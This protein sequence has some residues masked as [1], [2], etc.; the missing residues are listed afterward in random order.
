MPQAGIH[1]MVGVAVRR[2]LPKREWLMLGLVVGNLLPDADNLAVAVATVAAPA[3]DDPIRVLHRT[4]THS[5]FF[6]VTLMVVF[7]LVAR[8]RG[9]PRWGN[10]GLGL[11]A[12]VGMHMALD[13]LVW[14]NGVEVLWPIPSWVNLWSGYNPPDWFSKLMYPA[15]FLCFALYFWMLTGVARRRGTD[16]D[17]LRALRVWTWVQAGLFVLFTVLVYTVTAGFLPPYGV[18]YLLSL[19]LALYVTVR[20][21]ETVAAS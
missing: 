21:R 14:F 4:F 7:Y 17:F 16:G 20:M 9:Q 1:G 19:G 10:L 5:V 15:E 6:V 3:L 12:G 8:Q 11:G 13:L 18:A 2:W